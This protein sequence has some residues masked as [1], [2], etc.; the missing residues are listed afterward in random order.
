MPDLGP[1][2]DLRP[3]I[4]VGGL[5]GKVVGHSPLTLVQVFPLGTD[6]LDL[7]FEPHAKL[8]FYR[9]LPMLDQAAT[10]GGGSA[11]SIHEVIG[12]HWGNLRPADAEPLES[13]CLDQ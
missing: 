2:P 9:T 8:L 10:V 1:L 4:D 7:G 11:S 13:G 5:V 12:V 3:I 6:E